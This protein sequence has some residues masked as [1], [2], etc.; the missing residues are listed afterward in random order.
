MWFGGGAVRKRKAARR[1]ILR[2]LAGI[3]T[4]AG[5]S[6]LSEERE[7]DIYASRAGR[8]SRFDQGARSRS[9][10]PVG[11]SP[12]SGGARHGPAPAR[13]LVLSR[14]A[15]LPGADGQPFRPLPDRDRHPSRRRG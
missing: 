1:A 15:L 2:R 6:W 12:L 7:I 11:G 10:V 13:P 5:L 4:D 9:P 14:R 8:L 3:F